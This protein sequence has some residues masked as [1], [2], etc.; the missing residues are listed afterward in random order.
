MSVL[1]FTHPLRLFNCPC[2]F[3]FAAQVYRG[4]Y[5]YIYIIYVV[6]PKTLY[7]TV[8]FCRSGGVIP[9]VSCTT[10]THP[11]YTLIPPCR[12]RQNDPA[13]TRSCWTLFFITL[14]TSQLNC[15]YRVFGTCAYLIVHEYL[16]YFKGAGGVY[17]HHRHQKKKVRHQVFRSPKKELNTRKK[18][19]DTRL[20][21]VQKKSSTPSIPES[22]KN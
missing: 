12:G 7:K 1:K 14:G 22:D 11:N 9:L 10:Q 8:N 6:M 3:H 18:E 15:S 2:R 21:G 5:I 16:K 19:F 13:Q 4:G 20:S 17:Q